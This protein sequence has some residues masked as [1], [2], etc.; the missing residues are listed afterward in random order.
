L[1]SST[2]LGQKNYSKF[3]H[4]YIYLTP[5]EIPPSKDPLKEIITTRL[6]PNAIAIQEQLIMIK[7]Y[8][9]FKKFSSTL[10]VC[11]LCGNIV[12]QPYENQ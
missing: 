7:H 10:M 5:S 8:K 3:W 11:P 9:E 2:P 1:K 12:I 4:P 6:N